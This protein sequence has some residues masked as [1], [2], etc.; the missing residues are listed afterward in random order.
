MTSEEKSVKFEDKLGRLEKIVES[1][2]NGNLTI[3]DMMKNF[4]EGK[5]LVAAC[6]TELESIRQRIEKVVSAS[7]EPPQVEPLDIV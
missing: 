4:D 5:R 7:S 6:T 2:E 3:D 1:M